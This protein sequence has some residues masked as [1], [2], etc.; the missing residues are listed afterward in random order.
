M[1]GMDV[2]EP[3]RYGRQQREVD[4]AVVDEGPGTA[5]AVNHASYRQLPALEVVL[6]Q[7]AI[8]F[9]IA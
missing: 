3:G 6:I 8:Q 7:D 5:G 9:L 2:D 4:R 1:L